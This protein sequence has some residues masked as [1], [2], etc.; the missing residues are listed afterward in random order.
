[1]KLN[2]IVI[3]AVEILNQQRHYFSLIQFCKAVSD[4]VPTFPTDKIPS[5]FH[6]SFS[7]FQV[8]LMV[9]FLTEKIINLTNNT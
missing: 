3:N 5:L 2:K 4:M 8:L 1:M 6:N 7:F 9:T